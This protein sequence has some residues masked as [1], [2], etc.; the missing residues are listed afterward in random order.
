MKRDNIDFTKTGKC[1]LCGDKK[2]L[3]KVEIEKFGDYTACRTL[4]CQNCI[5][6][7]GASKKNG[8]LFV[9]SID[10]VPAKVAAISSKFAKDFGKLLSAEWK[11]K[12]NDVAKWIVVPFGVVGGETFGHPL[13]K[14]WTDAK[15]NAFAV[16]LEVI[17]YFNRMNPERMSC[18]ICGKPLVIEAPDVEKLEIND[19]LKFKC[20]DECLAFDEI[21]LVSL[22][23][24]SYD[25][26]VRK[27]NAG[28]GRYAYLDYCERERWK[29]SICAC[30]CTA[31]ALG[32][33]EKTLGRLADERYNAIH[34]AMY[35]NGG[36]CKDCKSGCDSKLH[37]KCHNDFANAHPELISRIV[38][39]IYGFKKGMNLKGLITT[40][41]E[42]YG[43]RASE[44]CKL[45]CNTSPDNAMH[46]IC[47]ATGEICEQYDGKRSCKECIMHV[48]G[49]PLGNFL[50][51][52]GMCQHYRNGKCLACCGKSRGQSHLDV[53]TYKANNYVFS[54]HEEFCK[55][56]KL[57]DGLD[58]D[59]ALE[60]S[61]A[62]K[63]YQ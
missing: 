56:F 57:R 7:C 13:L 55:K 30:S 23:R 59:I 46:G 52:A 58:L 45:W 38:D 63:S 17:N 53:C 43:Y 20:P 28:N 50:A 51:T 9:K 12:H 22:Y 49:K 31:Y 11:K 1:C 6:L 2:Q 5:K 29:N 25:D 19:V 14:T 21:E 62:G 10:D 61:K 54:T 35:E 3:S 4:M 60:A 41:K 27:L 47:G 15:D 16:K 32:L 24:D 36:P 34:N 44:H 33:V 48:E 37:K 40:L 8:Q 26:Y 18:P 42:S 39:Y